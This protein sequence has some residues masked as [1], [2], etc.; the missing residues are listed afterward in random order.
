ME[1]NGLITAIDDLK[2][3]VSRFRRVVL[4]SH[5]LG[6]YDYGKVHPS[7]KQQE[8]RHIDNEAS[9][10]EALNKTKIDV[11]AITDHMKCGFACSIS[12]ATSQGDVCVLPGME[13]NIRPPAPWNNFKLHIV[14][15]F[16]EKCSHEQ[17]CKILPSYIPSEQDR[18]GTE[19][20]T[21]IG[22]VDFISFVHKY[23]GLC[24]A[25]HIDSDRGVRKTFRQLGNDGI[26]FYGPG[27]QLTPEEEK[28]ISERFKEF[29]LLA[30][31]DAIEVAKEDDKQ[32]YSWVYGSDDQRTSIAVLLR[33]DAHRVED[34][35]IEEFHTHIKM[36][37]PCFEDLKQALRFPDTRIRFPGDVPASPSPR[38]L[39][40]EI[41]SGDG[42]GF[43]KN[44]Q[45]AFSDNLTCLI[46]PRGSGKSAIIEAIRY[47]FG[48]NKIL[49][50]I[51]QPG[52]DL[53]KTIRGLQEATLTNCVIRIPYTR[54]DG[55]IH[56]LEAT[57]DSKQDYNTKVYSIDGND[58]D[59]RDVFTNDN[60]PLRLFGWSEIETLGREASRQRDL[61]DRLIAGFSDM[62][63]ERLKLR[64]DLE[65]K[66]S[67]I[68]SSSSRLGEILLRDNEE[69]KR[70]K[71]YKAEFERLNTPEIDALFIDIDIAKEKLALLDKL[72][73]N[74]KN[75]S[76]AIEDA[77]KH[78]VLTGIDDLI[79]EASE[80]VQSWWK[81]S[82]LDTKI[83]SQSAEVREEL[84]KGI[85]I[86]DKF[87][88]EVEINAEEVNR[89]F[90]EKEIGIREAIGKEVTKQ[91]AAGLRKTANERLQRV[92]QLKR[93]Y[94]DEL[95]VFNQL[96]GEWYKITDEIN[97]QQE[98]ICFMRTQQK[99]EIEDTLNKF[100][101]PE[102]T[103]SIRLNPGGDRDNFI[104]HLTDKSL[105]TPQNAD[106]WRA[107][108]VP[109]KVSLVCTPIQLAKAILN[110]DSSILKGLFI[111]DPDIG[112]D[113]DIAERLFSSLHPFRVDEDADISI[114]DKGK[115][116]NILL[117]AEVEWDD[118]EGILLNG[119]AVQNLS[120]GQ[121]SSAMLPLIALVEDAPLIIDQ[122][123]DN[124]DNRLVGRMLVDI[125]ANLKEKRQIIV[126]THN[127]NIV[128]SGDAEQVIV[129]DAIS[130][131]EGECKHSGSI[132][133]DV[134]VKSIIEL[135]EGGKEAF[136]TRSRRYGY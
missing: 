55:Q 101:T 132:D 67:G 85:G 5:S 43:F 78:D 33:N 66:R 25:A 84:S 51:Q 68:L 128:V 59:V 124:L 17:I 94:V 97:K 81:I 32:H 47:V 7:A 52:A 83:A 44:L 27:E 96:L 40:I 35:D 15:I 109:L 18:D 88:A 133:N 4:H 86:L 121:R 108:K 11:L 70:Y 36:T 26:L 23:G 104:E 107:N 79:T 119:R 110:L 120:P 41:V 21:T 122:P 72:K 71:E 99:E 92:N 14:A 61:L 31:F 113:E 136:L 91:V 106:N 135:M 8:T 87:V 126:A 125:L 74:I 50:Q 39:G 6:S 54:K 2:S 48:F 82:E 19:E 73:S 130:I 98:L 24:I 90:Q 57:F 46:G 13:L 100:S 111:A 114:M 9:Y 53:P 12:E 118:E 20:I 10:L 105:F 129:L 115:L 29:L 103:I 95:N 64:A 76:I 38:I 75:W 22:L 77:T 116:G 62:L 58:L 65:I 16:P 127:P 34:L 3:R 102:M 30:G 123:E 49:D 80:Q 63:E 42:N 69:I 1:Y 117:L 28:Q 60:Y 37:K 134:I 112:L 45:A 93:E 131:S 56:I 89:E